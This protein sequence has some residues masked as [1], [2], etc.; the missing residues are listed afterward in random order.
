MSLRHVIAAT[1]L[2]LVGATLHAGPAQA[3]DA[4]P[5]QRDGNHNTSSVDATVPAGGTVQLTTP[6]VGKDIKTLTVTVKPKNT[7]A[8]DGDTFDQFAHSL[9]TLSKRKRLL[10]CTMLY[11][12]LVA[13]QDTYTGEFEVDAFF[14]T[15]AG[16][17]L[18]A[19]LQMAGFPAPARHARASAAGGKCAQFRPS[20]PATVTKVPGGYSVKASG[21]PK[22]A[23]KPK[24]KVKCKVTGHT[25][26][27]T[28]R[29]AKKGQPLRK[30]AGKKISLGIKSPPDAATSVPVRATFVM[31]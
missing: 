6:T 2:A 21:T 22:K 12:S 8:T 31:S 18:V 14:A 7:E 11:Q 4:D 19:C 25:V 9:G 24:V 1:T 29:S 16:A 23:K 30:A 26:R 17:V 20:L 10:V 5:A 27:Y 28:I 13:P 15:L 3:R